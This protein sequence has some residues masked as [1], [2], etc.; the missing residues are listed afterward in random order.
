M[1]A[2]T[3]E[4]ILEPLCPGPTGS[5]PADEEAGWMVLWFVLLLI[6]VAL[7]LEV[8]LL[9]RVLTPIVEIDGHIDQILEDG[10][11]LTGSLDGVTE[12]LAETKEVVSQVAAG[13]LRYGAGLN[14]VG[15]RAR[16]GY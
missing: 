10:V 2:R 13:A 15:T 6:I 14:K 5:R 1:Y 8:F 4:P 7:P 9:N 3:F 12:I 11:P 16:G